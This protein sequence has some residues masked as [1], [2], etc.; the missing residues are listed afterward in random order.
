MKATT[1]GDMS[2]VVQLVLN[3]ADINLAD[4]VNKTFLSVLLLL[5]FSFNSLDKRR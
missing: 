5:L 4:F 3:G 2:S 1:V